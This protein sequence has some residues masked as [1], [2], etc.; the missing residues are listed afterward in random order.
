MNNKN[1][2]VLIMKLNVDTLM[3]FT[4]VIKILITLWGS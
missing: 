1:H 3:I 2:E 4:L